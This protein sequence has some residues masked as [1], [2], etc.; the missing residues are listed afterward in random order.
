MSQNDVETKTSGVKKSEDEG[1]KSGK[2]RAEEITD[3]S[4][5]IIRWI[6]LGGLIPI[7]LC[8]AYELKLKNIF[9]VTSSGVMVALASA[10]VG[11]LVGFVFG[12]PRS[13]NYD[14]EIS[15]S[16]IETKSTNKG[17]KSGRAFQSN[18]NL[19][20][21]S[22]WL[23]KILVGVGLTQI[24]LFPEKL[25]LLSKKI[26]QA[27]VGVTSPDVLAGAIILFYSM[28]GFLISY[29]WSRVYLPGAF[30]AILI[31][32]LRADIKETKDK[33][34]DFERQA[35]KDAAAKS[36]VSRHLMGEIVDHDEMKQLILG[37]SPIAKHEIYQQTNLI[38][39]NSWKN[40]K[41]VMEKTIPI[42]S[43]LVESD[44]DFE[45]HE[46]HGR[47]GFVLKDK[48]EPEN[49]EAIKELSIAI[50]I[51]DKNGGPIFSPLYEACRAICKIRIEDLYDNVEKKEELNKD[52]HE[53]LRMAM[54]DDWIKGWINEE[55]DVKKW[56]EKYGITEI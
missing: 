52:I 51:R 40:N 8:G 43:Y 9:I 30:S 11:A 33:F 55:E 12:I 45:F 27:F 25:G 23:T 19:E 22:D 5:S 13:P 37:S 34:S 4:I 50:D 36:I 14:N 31:E 26:G 7:F 41:K 53:D 46:Y 28:C 56:K 6:M 16:G 32:S 39:Y 20:Q 44:K 47:L 24:T 10:L 54:G 42:F 29:L 49:E 15:N 2:S 38:R 3:S 17:E 48:V 1:Q 21:I 35:I 18:T